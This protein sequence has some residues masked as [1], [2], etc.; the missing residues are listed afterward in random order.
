MTARTGT[1]GKVI[2]KTAQIIIFSSVLAMPTAKLCNATVHRTANQTAS[3]VEL[4]SYQNRSPTNK[5]GG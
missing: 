1:A 5:G 4:H 3:I 2:I